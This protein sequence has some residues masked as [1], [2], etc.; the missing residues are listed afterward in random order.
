[1]SSW[2]DITFFSYH[3]TDTMQPSEVKPQ[4]TMNASSGQD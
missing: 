2:V 3:H 1:M 4:D